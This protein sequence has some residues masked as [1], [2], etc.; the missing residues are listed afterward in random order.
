MANQRFLNS[1]FSVR[2][3]IMIGKYLP[4]KTGYRISYIIASFI[5]LF[6]N[7]NINKSIRVNQ[8]IVN[9]ETNTRKEL[10]QISKNIL[11][12]AGRCY[13]DY[14]HFYNRP[15]KL[16][17]VVPLTEPMKEFIKLSQNKQGYMVVA[18]HLSNFDLVVS[19]MAYSGFRCNILS[20]PNPGS[21]Y[22]LQNEIRTASGLDVT[23]LGDSSV[24][25]KIIQYLKDGGMAATGID[26]PVPGR[27]KRHYIKFF[28]KPSPLPVGY[29]TTALAA[30]VPIIA[31]AAFMLPN[32]TYGFKHSG[33]IQLKKYQNKLDEIILNAET[34]LKKIEEFIKPAPEQWLM[35]YP[36]WPEHTK[37]GI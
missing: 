23:P 35:Y 2:L 8:Y 14:Y 13:Y 10:D 1:K 22:Q 3:S 12:H 31:V 33:P 26:R 25:A 6:P 32:G 4:Q 27:K 28:G 37:E 16:D 34:V 20:Y 24:E 5:S 21:G 30:D 9:G 7:L 29:L 19:Q 18:P 17:A 11:T 15:E 36:V